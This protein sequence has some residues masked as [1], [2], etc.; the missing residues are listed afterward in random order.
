MKSRLAEAS[1]TILDLFPLLARRVGRLKARRVADQ[2]GVFGPRNDFQDDSGPSAP[3]SVRDDDAAADKSRKEGRRRRRA[4]HPTCPPGSLAGRQ[5]VS[6]GRRVSGWWMAK[7]AGGSLPR[8]R[9]FA[10]T[11]AGSDGD[12]RA[13]EAG[14]GLVLPTGDRADGVALVGRDAEG[15]EDAPVL[16]TSQ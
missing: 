15:E 10:E 5:P 11:V 3:P 12:R 6:T 8:R 7:S 14:D 4:S 1:T 9:A 13:E 2:D 16:P